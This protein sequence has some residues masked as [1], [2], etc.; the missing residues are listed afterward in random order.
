MGIMGGMGKQGCPGYY[1]GMSLMLAEILEQPVVLERTLRREMS[2]ARRFRETLRR[3]DIRMVILVARGTSD[4][5]ATFGRYLIEIT[6][7]LP[8]S[9]A[10]PS[11]HTLYKTNLRLSNALVVGI[12]QSGAGPD[13]N[14]VLESSRQRGALTLGITNEPDSQLTRMVDECWLVHAGKEHSVAATKTYTGQLLL[15]YLLAWA[16]GATLGGYMNS[17][18]LERLPDLAS[19]TLR[20]RHQIEELVNRYRFMNHA[21]VVGRGLNYASAFEL[22][23]KLMETCYVVTERFSSADFLHGPI[24]LVQADFPVFVFAPPGPTFDQQVSLLERLRRLGADTLVFTGRSFSGQATKRIVIPHTGPGDLYTPI[25]YI[26]PGQLF[27]ACL[28]AAKGINPDAPRQLAKVTQ[29]V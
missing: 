1:D 18:A 10:A 9:L 12:S 27:T 13:V 17:T 2:K 4:N 26:I 20:L 7:G 14:Q 16:L 21:I 15:L 24:A 5:A 19:R 8:V 29:T 23:L 22:A 28:A 25:P 3:R 6:T 11:V